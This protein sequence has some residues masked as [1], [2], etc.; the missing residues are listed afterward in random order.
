MRACLSMKLCIRDRGYTQTADVDTHSAQA[1]GSDSESEDV[2]EQSSA[3]R[4][5]TAATATAATVAIATTAATPVSVAPATAAMPKEAAVEE[6]LMALVRRH[7]TFTFRT[8]ASQC[9]CIKSNSPLH[10]PGLCWNINIQGM[11]I[12][13]HTRLTS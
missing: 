11:Y 7:G 5:A 8:C 9:A 12:C 6:A 10:L 13:E 2:S 4:L 1:T 3:W